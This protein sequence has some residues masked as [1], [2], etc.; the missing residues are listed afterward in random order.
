M[1]YSSAPSGSYTGLIFETGEI[2]GFYDDRVLWTQHSLMTVSTHYGICRDNPRNF[3]DFV[4]TG[5]GT[6]KAFRIIGTAVC[7][8]G[9]VPM[10]LHTYSDCTER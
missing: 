4:S 7:E 10:Y 1:C 3:F 9:L 2:L 5:L 6:N 8:V